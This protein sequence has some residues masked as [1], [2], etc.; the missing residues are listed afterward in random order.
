MKKDLIE[1]QLGGGGFGTFKDDSS[2]SVSMPSVEKSKREKDLEKRVRDETDSGRKRELREQLDDLRDRRSARTGAS[3]SNG[4]RRRSARR[5]GLPGNGCRAVPASTCGTR[6]RSGGDSPEE[7][8]AALADYVDFSAAG[9]ETRT[10]I[11]V[12]AAQPR[13]SAGSMPRKGMTRAEAEREF[14][15]PIEVSDHREGALTMTTLVFVRDEQRIATDFVED[16]LV[17][18][19]ITSR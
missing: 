11:S 10:D 8:M 4:L 15:T 17:R 3:K 9:L 6:S 5:K 7:L 16:V 18:Y 14:G 2:S 12:P 13:P 1:F 19:L